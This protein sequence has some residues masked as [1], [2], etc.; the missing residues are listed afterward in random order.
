MYEGNL[1]KIP[2]MYNYGKRRASL[3]LDAKLGSITDTCALFLGEP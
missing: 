3:L 1:F 2:L